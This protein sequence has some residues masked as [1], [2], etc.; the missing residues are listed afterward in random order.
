MSDLLATSAETWRDGVRPGRLDDV[1]LPLR[2][3]VGARWAAFRRRHRLRRRDAEA[4]YRE[5]R[6]PK[7][8]F[9]VASGRAAVGFLGSLMPGRRGPLIAAIVLNL[10]AA[11]VGL[12]APFLLGDLVD[13]AT[14][15][16][17]QRAGLDVLALIIVGV[18]AAHATLTFLA[19]RAA[20]VLGYDLLAAAREEVV[21]LVLRLPL[22]FVERVGSG[23]LLTRIT[24][25][26]SKMA[27]AVRWAL[28]HLISAVLL[29]VASVVA[30]LVNSWL[31]TL[32]LLATAVIMFF[33]G[34][35][36]LRNVLAGY[37]AE[38]RSYS[39]INSTMT[40]SVEG[41]RTVEALRLGKSRVAQLD[42]DT[43][44][45]AQAERYTMT[46]RNIL[47]GT[48]DASFQLPMIGVIL[49]GTWGY[50]ADLVT[51]GQI[52]TAALLVQ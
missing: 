50:S 24:S 21:R 32:P 33:G 25:D 22:G 4:T 7:T 30:M 14:G 41:A 39:V 44:L 48:V 40:E 20:A 29:V 23:D 1:F 15:G 52:T 42:E 2:G 28:P 12:V 9:P 46:L 35:Y 49:L 26:V 11:V 6:Q 19:R 27:T 13:R 38:S 36:Y 16:T 3:G 37:V 10:V 31:L 47:F 45:S 5:S 17:L 43:E 8:G 18:V 34:R 51:V